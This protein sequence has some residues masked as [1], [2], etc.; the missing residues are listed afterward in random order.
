MDVFEYGCGN[1][2]LWWAS[3]VR[4]IVS[5]EH[6]AAWYQQTR[7]TLPQNAELHHVAL[8]YGGA[9]S[10]LITRYSKEFDIVFIDGRD[11][12][13]CINHCLPALKSGG[14]VILD[15]S[16]EAEYVDGIQFLSANEFKQLHFAGPGPITAAIWRT[17]V[18]Y[19]QNNCLGI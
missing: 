14:V 18:F 16:D 10:Q 17:T 5:C 8:E 6:D 2:T 11:R 1:S 19:K 7:T 3:R 12:V 4:R 15:N 9:Y 13:N